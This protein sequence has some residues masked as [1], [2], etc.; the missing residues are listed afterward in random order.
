MYG[1]CAVLAA[2]QRVGEEPQS[3]LAEFGTVIPNAEARGDLCAVLA[4]SST[5]ASAG[6]EVHALIRW[7]RNFHRVSAARYALLQRHY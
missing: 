6:L 7:M 4:G 3:V 2:H 1:R 5:S